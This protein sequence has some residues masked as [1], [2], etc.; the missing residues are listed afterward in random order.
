MVWESAKIPP[1]QGS[2]GRMGNGQCCG[3]FC[4]KSE[5]QKFVSFQVAIKCEVRPHSLAGSLRHVTPRFATGLKILQT[6]A[7][8]MSMDPDLF[9][10]LAISGMPMAFEEGNAEVPFLHLGKDET[11]IH[12]IPLTDNRFDWPNEIPNTLATKALLFTLRQYR[13]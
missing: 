3:F 1:A 11:E 9:E 7:T 5:R 8:N 4:L 2:Q 12:P 6:Q 10:F 13:K